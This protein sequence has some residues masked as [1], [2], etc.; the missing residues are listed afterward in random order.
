MGEALGMSA[1]R[2]DI[3]SI[4]RHN[5]ARNVEQQGT[6]IMNIRCFL[7]KERALGMLYIDLRPVFAFGCGCSLQEELKLALGRVGHGL[8]NVENNIVSAKPLD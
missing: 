3:V 1:E 6:L 7:C 4:N 8:V 5:D 2:K